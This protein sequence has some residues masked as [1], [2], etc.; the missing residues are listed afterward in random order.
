MRVPCSP[1][2]RF[3]VVVVDDVPFHNAWLSPVMGHLMIATSVITLLSTTW[4]S[5]FYVREGVILYGYHK[6]MYNIVCWPFYCDYGDL[7]ILWTRFEQKIIP[8]WPVHNLRWKWWRNA[9]VMCRKK[10]KAVKFPKKVWCWKIFFIFCPWIIWGIAE[11]KIWHFNFL[12]QF[13][14]LWDEMSSTLG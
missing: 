8:L 6:F 3:H 7:L 4:Y 2:Q 12:L 1:W 10:K 11:K 9:I 13:W 5:T 14:F